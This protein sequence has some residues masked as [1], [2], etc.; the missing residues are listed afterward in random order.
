[1]QQAFRPGAVW[2][3]G[4]P[5]TLTAA[6]EVGIALAMAIGQANPLVAAVWS[7]L[8]RGEFKGA[9][10]PS[11]WLLVLLVRSRRRFSL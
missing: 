2:T 9:P 1:M 5:E 10:R 7:V 11:K 6:N 4:T 3:P 8:M